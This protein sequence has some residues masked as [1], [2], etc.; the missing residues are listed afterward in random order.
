MKVLGFSTSTEPDF[1][2]ILNFPVRRR[3]ILA[4]NQWANSCPKT[5]IGLNLQINLKVMR[6]AVQ[7]PKNQGAADTKFFS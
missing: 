6:P 2:P 5:Y 7:A 4:A 1:K 3:Q